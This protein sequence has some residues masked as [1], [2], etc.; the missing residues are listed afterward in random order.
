M[1]NNENQNKS[2][3]FDKVRQ[4]GND[5]L[6]IITNDGTTFV[7]Q[8]NENNN[9]VL[10]YYVFDVELTKQEASGNGNEPTDKKGCRGNINYGLTALLALAA[11]M[12]VKKQRQTGGN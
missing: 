6:Q 3:T 10:R 12:F 11:I 8:V 1:E 4:S 7:F 2:F 5:S 9:L